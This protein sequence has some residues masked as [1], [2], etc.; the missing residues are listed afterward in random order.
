MRVTGCWWLSCTV[1]NFLLFSCF[2]A[3]CS[4]EGLVI[5]IVDITGR[6]TAL[7]NYE[8]TVRVSAQA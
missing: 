5:G 7:D 2:F 1:Q 6:Q 4:N 8:F 3:E